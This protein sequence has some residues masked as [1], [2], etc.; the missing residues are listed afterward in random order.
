MGQSFL[1]KQFVAAPG[2]TLTVYA[3]ENTDI[4]VADSLGRK[5][6]VKNSGSSGTAIFKGLSHQLWTISIVSNSNTISQNLFINNNQ[7]AY[8]S[9]IEYIYNQGSIIE[10]W[11]VLNGTAV[12]DEENGYV[13]ISGGT[14]AIAYY[15]IDL[16]DYSTLK[17]T[18]KDLEGQNT[19][20]RVFTHTSNSY[21]ANNTVA[22]LD[23]NNTTEGTMSLDISALS[24]TYGIRVACYK[25][26]GTA[27]IK[28]QKLYLVR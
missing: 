19:N 20:V 16:T 26:S 18:Y 11:T 24:G 12:N 15:N 2:A 14:G 4:T 17:I 10:P 8:L 1:D 9:F 7:R 27:T 23:L 21:N 3:P 22:T 28:M 6:F 25:K 5:T 13:T